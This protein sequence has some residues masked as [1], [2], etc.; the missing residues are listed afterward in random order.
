[1]RVERFTDP[2]SL[3]PLRPA[4]NA[5]AGG[6]PFRRYDWLMPWWRHFGG[7]QRLCVLG[8]FE[9]ERLIGLAPWYR[10]SGTAGG[11]T[12]RFLGDG[13]VC[14][15]YLDILAHPDHAYRVPPLVVDWLSDA[16]QQGNESWDVLEWENLEQNTPIASRLSE[17]MARHQA[18]VNRLPAQNCWRLELPESWHDFEMQQSKSHRKQIRRQISRVLDTDRCRLHVCRGTAGLDEALAILTDLHMRRRKSLGQPGCFACDKFTGF[19][20]EATKELM[21]DG[22]S[23]I[24]W[25]DLDGQPVAA[26]VH[27]LGGAVSYA[28]QAGI[29][30]ERLHEE[31]G[32]LMQIAVIRRAIEQGRQAVDFLRGDEPYKAHWRAQPRTCE[33][34]RIVPN[35]TSGLIRHGIWTTQ[36]Q[37]KDWV[38]AGLAKSGMI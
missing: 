5:L 17:Q 1:M 11:Q 27:F 6:V 13:P 4:W 10:T 23:E 16:L 7:D 34:V 35:T 21:A 3:A 15:D 24:L 2:D 8:V 25:L 20:H 19:L 31:P 33:T 37:L 26:E 32:S 28:Y 29:D 9:D 14:T 36:T 38:R 30:P 22:L 18:I 12:L